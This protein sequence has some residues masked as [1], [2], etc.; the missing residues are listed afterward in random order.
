[1]NHWVEHNF[2]WR[3]SEKNSNSW[4]GSVFRSQEMLPVW[5]KL[6]FTS[7][8]L[9]QPKSPLWMGHVIPGQNG[10]PCPDHTVHFMVIVWPS[11]L[12]RPIPAS[13][14]HL[15]FLWD[16]GRGN[17]GVWCHLKAHMWKWDFW[18]APLVLQLYSPDWLSS[19]WHEGDRAGG[20]RRNGWH[21]RPPGPH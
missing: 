16:R 4:K 15:H 8:P 11:S 1:M 7:T 17:V 3:F 12:K 6:R 10:E 13:E 21:C 19:L 20:D 9:P 14:A 18:P 2:Y 5:G